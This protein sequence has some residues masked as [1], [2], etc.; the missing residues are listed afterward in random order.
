M[1]LFGAGNPFIPANLARVINKTG[2]PSIKGYVVKPSAITD[3]A[4]EYTAP[5]NANPI[6]VIYE[7]NIPDG[8]Y[9]YIAVSSIA[10]VYY[11][12]SVTRGNIARVATAGEAGNGA[13]L[14]NEI[15]SPPFVDEKHF[16]ECGHP[17]ESRTGAGLA[18]TV[19][20]FN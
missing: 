12:A 8:E 7:D 15:L 6:G 4:V 11:R 10:E 2:A 18:K 5:G 3:N 14:V 19:L 13:Q 20:H 16:Q 9:M 17:I 1:K